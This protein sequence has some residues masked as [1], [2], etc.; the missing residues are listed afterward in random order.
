MHYTVRATVRNTTTLLDNIRD[1]HNKCDELP[2]KRMCPGARCNKSGC[3]SCPGP[4]FPLLLPDRNLWYWQ[5]QSCTAA[6]LACAGS[7]G[8][9]GCFKC[10]CLNATSG[11]MECLALLPVLWGVG[12]CEVLC[13]NAFLLTLF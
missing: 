6:G 11:I 3:L 2:Y 13:I 1:Y 5:C 8:A 12:R 9:K 4:K 7:C 10:E